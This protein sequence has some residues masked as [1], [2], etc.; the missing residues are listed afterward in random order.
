MGFRFSSRRRRAAGGETVMSDQERNASS[1]NRRD[2][3][4]TAGAGLTA[5][6]IALTPG[7]TALAQF[8][9]DKDRLLRIAS[10]TWPIRSIF[11]ARA[12]GG[13]GG[14][15]GGRGAAPAAATP[16]PATTQPGAPAATP[17]GAPASG[18]G[19]DAT[20]VVQRSPGNGGWST[21]R[22]KER[23]GEITMLDFP[24]FTKDN[25]P[26]VTHMDLFS[27]LFG[28][29]T[30]DSMYVRRPDGGFGTFDPSTA[31]SRR[32]LDQLVTKMS[33]AGVKCQHISNNAPTNLAGPDEAQRKEGVE[34][35][36]KWLAG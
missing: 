18:R 35:A 12:G 32:W 11:K 6:G 19:A 29:V 13:R 4:R 30:D 17:S 22:M 25:F 7:E 23:Y 26:G 16:A 33:A 3:F 10:C 2:F 20:P 34:I 5:A 21:Q 24:Q 36:K 9:S 28:D 31:S 15:G 14:G 1:V 8:Q 27:G